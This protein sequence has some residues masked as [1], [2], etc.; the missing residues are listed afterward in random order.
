MLCSRAQLL[1]GALLVTAGCTHLDTTRDYNTASLDEAVVGIPYALPALHYELQVEHAIVACPQQY[2]LTDGSQALTVWD[3]GLKFKTN[4]VAQPHYIAGERFVADYRSLASF[5]KTTGYGLETYPSGVLKSINVSAEDQTAPLIKDAVGIGLTI[6]RLAGGPGGG[7]GVATTLTGNASMLAENS[8]DDV[9][10]SPLAKALA[11]LKAITKTINFP[12]CRQEIGQVKAARSMAADNVKKIS[13]EL[14]LATR[15]VSRATLIATNDHAD[16]SDLANFE[17][18][19]AEQT[20]AETRLQDAVAALGKSQQALTIQDTL[21]W[22]ATQSN[23]AGV[24]KPNDPKR[25]DAIL[26]VRSEPLLRSDDF[27]AWWKRLATAVKIEIRQR[28]PDFVKAYGVAEQDPPDEP[29]APSE[30]IDCGSKSV[31]DCV[32]PGLTLYPSLAPAGELRVDPQPERARAI[33]PTS[34]KALS[35]L[36]IRSQHLADLRVCLGVNATTNCPTENLV[37]VERGVP[38]PQLGQLRFLPFSSRPFEAAQLSLAMR[39]DGSVEKFEYKKTK[40]MSSGSEAI[41]D[42]ITQYAA[43]RDQQK[44]ETTEALAASRAEAIAAVEHRI[45]L[46]TKQAE[47]LKLQT[48]PQP[49]ALKAIQD[50]TALI[51]AQAALLNAKLSQLKAEAALA[52]ASTGS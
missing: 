14:D 28:F 15:R 49:D 7:G 46:L 43:F 11:A 51:E 24:L 31:V 1:A 40:A 37:V 2:T 32:V 17:T 3:D 35:G 44:K 9:S 6:A 41:K 27:A 16:H 47:L 20:E 39:E 22:T 45:A 10:P 36:F 29:V 8:S 48:P 42:A 26:F 18:K 23:V 34:T 30:P 12:D 21:G 13:R 33:V 25:F 38:T 5:M 50:E 4:V 19:L 52:Q